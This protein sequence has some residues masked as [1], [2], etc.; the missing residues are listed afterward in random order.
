MD[1]DRGRREEG[2]E[3]FK[4][5]SERLLPLESQQL[6][7]KQKCRWIMRQLV[8]YGR[9]AERPELLTATSPRLIVQVVLKHTKDFQEETPNLIPTIGAGKPSLGPDI[10]IAQVR[11][12]ANLA[13]Q[14]YLSP[15]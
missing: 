8:A 3:Q 15:F 14:G 4:W 7:R 12:P 13:S 11:T 2:E 9:T 10:N 5:T 1:Q 6:E